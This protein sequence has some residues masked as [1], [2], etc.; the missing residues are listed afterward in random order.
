MPRESGRPSHSSVSV[1]VHF[2]RPLTL[3]R[4]PGTFGL[5]GGT[6]L[7]VY[8]KQEAPTSESLNS[9]STKLVTGGTY[10]WPPL[11]KLTF[12]FAV[13]T[14][15]A[16]QEAIRLNIEGDRQAPRLIPH[17]REEEESIS[18]D[19]CSEEVPERRVLP[20]DVVEIIAPLLKEKPKPLESFEDPC[21]PDFVKSVTRGMGFTEPT[22]I[23][24]YCRLSLIK[25]SRLLCSDA[26]W[27]Q[28]RKPARA[29][30]S[31]T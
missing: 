16:S 6:S 10:K 19:G 21:I 27:S 8:L 11:P 26:T 9:L 18:L 22:V 14:A 25:P 15:R 23:Q 7:S 24:K 29:R 20:E 2:W 17:D 4:L 3:W 31:A 13:M 1:V 5:Y 28:L 30:P 12:N